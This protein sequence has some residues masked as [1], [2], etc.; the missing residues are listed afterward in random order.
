MDSIHIYGESEADD[1]PPKH[2]C[3]CVDKSGIMLSGGNLGAKVYHIDAVSPYPCHKI[4]SYGAW[5]ISTEFTNMT[6][7]NF[8]NK[9]RCGARQ[10]VFE[11]NPYSADFIPI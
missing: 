1:C 4:K 7:E 5:N 6:F 9:T 8:S 10:R 3:Y 11:R 2:R